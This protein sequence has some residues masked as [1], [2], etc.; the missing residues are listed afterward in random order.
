MWRLGGS[1]SARGRGRTGHPT[2]HRTCPFFFLELLPFPSFTDSQ[3][4]RALSQGSQGSFLA[5]SILFVYSADTYSVHCLCPCG[6]HHL[7]Y[8]VLLYYEH[9]QIYIKVER[10]IQ[11][12]QIYLLPK[13]SCIKI[14]SHILYLCL[15]VFFFPLLKFSEANPRHVILP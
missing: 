10:I 14:F 12:P 6:A 7:V 4:F 1:S 5:R 11:R 9:F 15:F 8:P 2:V 13:L 3:L